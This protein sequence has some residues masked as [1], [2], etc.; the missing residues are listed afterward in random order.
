MTRML[1]RR[2][3]LLCYSILLYLSYQV[4]SS[5]EGLPNILFVVIDDLGSGDLGRHSSNIDTP[6]LDQLVSDGVNLENYYVL[7]YCSP[8]RASIMSGRYPLH[9]GCHS[10]V[11]DYE[12]QGLPLDEG[13]Q[14]TFDRRSIMS[15][16]KV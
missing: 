6:V 3:Y 16:I 12:T 10:I 14:P 8:T 7:P 9:T 1:L 11:L 15:S 5:I 2:A 13:T 4:L